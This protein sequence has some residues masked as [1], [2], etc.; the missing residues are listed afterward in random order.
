MKV[1]DK[2]GTWCDARNCIIP[3]LQIR[4]A[5]GMAASHCWGREGWGDIARQTKRLHHISACPT[6]LSYRA[7]TTFLNWRQG[8]S[9]ETS[10]S[11]AMR[12]IDQCDDTFGEGPRRRHNGERGDRGNWPGDEICLDPLHEEI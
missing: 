2:I 9:K 11:R 7:P 12:R 10:A 1:R 4:C 8:T 5:F 3:A 6:V